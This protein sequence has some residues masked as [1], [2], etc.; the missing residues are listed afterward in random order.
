MG[1][2]RYHFHQ[3]DP[4]DG[5]NYNLQTLSRS[6]YGVQNTLYTHGQKIGHCGIIGVAV[7]DKNRD[8]LLLGMPSLQGSCHGFGPA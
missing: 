5:L 6:F 4:L 8:S 1:F 7:L 2:R 3:P